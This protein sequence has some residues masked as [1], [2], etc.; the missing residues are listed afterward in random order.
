MAKD[1][2]DDFDTTEK[3]AKF[4][5]FEELHGYWWHSKPDAVTKILKVT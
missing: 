5:L 4:Y 1:F 2:I 3:T